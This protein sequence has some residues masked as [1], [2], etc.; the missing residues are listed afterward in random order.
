MSDRLRITPITFKPVGSHMWTGTSG[1]WLYCIS[2]RPSGYVAGCAGAT[3]YDGPCLAAAQIA[4]QVH[5]RTAVLGLID[6]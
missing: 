5:H 4:V 6:G 1:G 3:I 2:S